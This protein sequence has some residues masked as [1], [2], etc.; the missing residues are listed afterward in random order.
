MTSARRAFL[1][2]LVDFAFGSGLVTILAGVL[3]LV[4]GLVDGPRLERAAICRN[5]QQRSCLE[6]R[7]GRVVSVGGRNH[8]SVAYDDGR[9]EVVLDLPG[10]AHPP[11]QAFVRVELWG[12]DAVSISDRDGRRYKDQ[13]LWPVAWNGWAFFWIG[14][15]FALLLPMALTTKAWRVRRWR[16]R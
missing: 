3:F 6:A 13:T 4:T 12:G 14:V 16:R 7:S 15:G 5:A 10:R 1:A 11:V 9:S 2:T 8:V